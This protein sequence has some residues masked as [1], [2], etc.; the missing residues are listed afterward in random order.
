MAE[1][2]EILNI[3]VNY[4]D[5]IQKIGNF[6]DQINRAKDDQKLF[7]EELKKWSNYAERVFT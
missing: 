2:T 1:R 5:A 4:E 7:K 3:Q 6:T